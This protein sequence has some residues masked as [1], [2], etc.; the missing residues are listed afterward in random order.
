MNHSDLL[1]RVQQWRQQGKTIV[2]TNGCFD[3]L[4]AGHIA[5]LTE[6]AS[7]GDCLVVGLNADLSVKKLKGPSRPINDQD[8]RAQVIAALA[9]VDAVTLFSE[10][11]PRELI[12]S[13]LPD[14]LVK[15]GDYTVEQIAGA[16]EVIAAGGRVII[17]PIVEGF[18][19]SNIIN[20]MKNS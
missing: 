13:I 6:A 14:V 11:T 1:A 8:A 12:A 20:K 4:H 19:T 10:D 7:Y 9:V 3:V 15:G 18:S 5:S 17:N 2:F 16:A